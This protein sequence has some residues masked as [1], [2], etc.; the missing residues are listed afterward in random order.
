MTEFESILAFIYIL[1]QF[2]WIFYEFTQT[3]ISFN[4]KE[5]VVKNNSKKLPKDSTI[6]T[7]SLPPLSV[8]L[9]T[10]FNPTKVKTLSVKKKASLP[11]LKPGTTF[12]IITDYKI[13]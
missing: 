6:G 8:E 13:K 10:N 2:L 7:K 3:E 9:D 1:A 11:S 5:E 4:E 12:E